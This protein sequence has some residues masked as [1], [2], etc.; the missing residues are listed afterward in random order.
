MLRHLS[1]RQMRKRITSRAA[2][3][4]YLDIRVDGSVER[5]GT[6]KSIGHPILDRAAIDAFRQWRFR[7]HKTNWTVR[8]PVRYVDGPFRVDSA[9]SRPPALG[10]GMLITVFSGK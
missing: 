8:V 10:W 5:V 2:V 7:P 3:L 6:L 4:S 1:I 9:M